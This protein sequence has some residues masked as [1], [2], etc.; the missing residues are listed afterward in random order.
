MSARARLRLGANR[1]FSQP[2]SF[3][4]WRRWEDRLSRI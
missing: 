4:V 2:L 3:R 1:Y